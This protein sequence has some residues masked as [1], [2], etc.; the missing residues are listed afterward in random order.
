[1]PDPIAL[2]R[3]WLTGTPA[4]QPVLL[5]SQDHLM[6]RWRGDPKIRLHVGFCGRPPV[7]LGVG[8]DKGQVLPLELRES[9]H[10][11]TSAVQRAAVQRR[12]E[13]AKRAARAKARAARPLQ[14]RVGRPM[15]FRHGWFRC[16]ARCFRSLSQR[17]MGNHITSPIRAAKRMMA[18]T[19]VRFMERFSPS[20]P[21][22]CGSAARACASAAT[23]G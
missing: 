10:R 19:T 15:Q 5:E 8:G 16:V 23:A 7:D 11:G 13:R 12:D 4:D 18:S 22:D 14:R 21:T 2:H 1:M 20:R 3:T 17:R 6:D 9:R